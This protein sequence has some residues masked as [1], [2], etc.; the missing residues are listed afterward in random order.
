MRRSLKFKIVLLMSSLLVAVCI[1]L[2]F[3]A[4]QDSYKAL[5]TNIEEMLPKVAM[6]ASRVVETKITGRINTLE[7]LAANS[8]LVNTNTPEPEVIALLK[9]VTE[10]QGYKQMGY[11]KANGTIVYNTGERGSITETS[12][13]QKTIQG[14]AAIEGPMLNPN[15]DGIDMIY[16]VPVKS[17]DG[18][19]GVLIAIADGYELS[20][21][22]KEIIV[23][24]TG[25]VFIS[26]KNGKT[27][28]HSDV[29]I[30]KNIIES[31]TSEVDGVSSATTNAGSGEADA[32]SS[33]TVPNLAQNSMG[34]EN[35]T[36]VLAEMVKGE[37]G[38]GEYSYNGVPMF[39]GY[40]P[41]SIADWSVAVQ[42][43]K[44]E[45]MAGVNNLVW[46]IGLT[47]LAFLV[48]SII[49]VYFFT[50][51]LTKHLERLKEY[52]VR[53]GALDLSFEI[54]PD[55]LKQKDEIG[56]MSKSFSSFIVN[57]REMVTRIM[58]ETK[59]VNEAVAASHQNI[60][61]LSEALAEASATVQQV[62]AGM[63]E[64]ASS[65]DQI[66]E[67]SAEIETA[68]ETVAEKAEEGAISANE[69]SKK[70]EELKAKSMALQEDA[71]KRHQSIK[72]TMDIA[73]TKADEVERL[74]ALA[75]V[76]MDISS[77]TNLLALNAAIEAA[78]AGET[79][80]G[81]AVVAEEIRKLADDSKN[82]VGEIQNTLNVIFES[83]QS[84]VDA[85][86]SVVEYL[87]TK[88]VES[89]KD[90]VV[91]GENY[92]KDAMY[93]NEWATDLSATS[94]ELLA[95]I[96]SV[97]AT[98]AEISNASNTVSEGTNH[99]ADE[100]M[101]IKAQAVE[102]AHETDLIKQSSKDLQALVVKFK[103]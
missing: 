46:G 82:T 79:G 24:H 13:F 15:G 86:R 36:K 31:K 85:S 12:Y 5:S 25:N 47:S 19:V 27:I 44:S 43:E 61:I 60:S 1:G 91:V 37:S 70:A 29:E 100:I 59:S 34:F 10:R 7:V 97:S 33:A 20:E 40:A 65:T 92:D 72:E 17:G 52:T 99:I 74:R 69:I 98:I 8:E 68:V 9:Q 23:G 18:N 67:T 6:E 63:T 84:L 4:Y 88:V 81:F 71:E 56:E 57:V 95:S 39:L 78:R 45:L 66:A 77:K 90:S 28:A 58:K 54:A 3:M 30:L 16:A 32:V 87:E 35:Y 48:L 11:A 102:I 101:R 73:L 14:E 38:F 80:R 76:I 96:K 50:K 51:G 75:D 94:E 93:I 49:V 42:V 62:A 83:V 55:L 89:Y 53:A 26:A 2:G 41:V 21:L 64:T 22:A 103:V